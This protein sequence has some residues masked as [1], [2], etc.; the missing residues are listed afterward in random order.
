[1]TTPPQ[2]EREVD[3]YVGGLENPVSTVSSFDPLFGVEKSFESVL[4]CDT[5]GPRRAPLD[6]TQYHPPVGGGLYL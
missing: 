2:G 1:M 3:C 6:S 4:V 5:R